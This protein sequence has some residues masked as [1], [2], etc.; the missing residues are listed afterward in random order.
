M[1][2]R[3]APDALPDV[4]N[5]TLDLMVMDGTFAMGP[6]NQK[7]IRALAVTTSKRI[8]LAA[9]CCRPWTRPASKASS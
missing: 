1:A 2:Y 9:G 3:T 8:P 5:G 4:T 6:I 7:K